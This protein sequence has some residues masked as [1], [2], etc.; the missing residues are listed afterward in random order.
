MYFNYIKIKY[1]NLLSKLN[2]IT[3]W[4]FNRD[5]KNKD[6]TL[7]HKSAGGKFSKSSACVWKMEHEA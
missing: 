1:V 7:N 2:V 5:F 4:F 6:V 3:T